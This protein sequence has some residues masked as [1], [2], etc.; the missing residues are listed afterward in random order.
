MYICDICKTAFDEPSTHRETVVE[1]G[2]IRVVA[3]PLCPVCGEPYFTAADLCPKCNAWKPRADRL[4]S[5]CR[6]DLIHRFTDFA[7]TLTAEEETQLD[8]WLD[9]DSVTSRREWT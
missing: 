6:R 5:G 2:R 9:G 7:D 3:S 1:D 4:C 8:D